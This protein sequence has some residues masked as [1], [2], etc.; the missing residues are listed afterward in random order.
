MTFAIL[1]Y[2]VVGDVEMTTAPYALMTEL[3]DLLYN[4]CIA[5]T[6][7]Y[8]FFYLSHG[9]DKGMSDYKNLQLL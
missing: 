2:E 3:H 4:Q 8:S 1:K 6:S 5:N 9:S 7:C